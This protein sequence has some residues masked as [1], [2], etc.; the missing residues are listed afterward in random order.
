[1][2]CD[3][4]I[5]NPNGKTIAATKYTNLYV[6]IFSHFFFLTRYSLIRRSHASRLF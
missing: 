3:R 2:L 4:P 5:P 6:R 1:M